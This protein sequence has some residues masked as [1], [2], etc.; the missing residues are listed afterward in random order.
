MALAVAVWVCTLP[1]VFLLMM[2]W[3]GVLAAVT[4]AFVLLGGVTAVCW[5]VC[6]WRL[7]NTDSADDREIK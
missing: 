4:A 5:A 7:A 1:F 3:R 6:N 2:P